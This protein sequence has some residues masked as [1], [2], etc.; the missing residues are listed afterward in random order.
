MKLKELGTF[1]IALVGLNTVALPMTMEELGDALQTRFIA[2]SPSCGCTAERNGVNDEFASLALEQQA[3][4]APVIMPVGLT[5][6]PLSG[7]ACTV[8]EGYWFICLKVDNDPLECQLWG[9]VFNKYV[10]PGQNWHCCISNWVWLEKHECK[11]VDLTCTSGSPET[12]PQGCDP[13]IP[14]STECDC[15]V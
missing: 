11:D 14:S 10:C 1:A 15:G 7:G 4:P 12:L 13:P 6:C 2:P 5:P 9:R 3:V 8:Q